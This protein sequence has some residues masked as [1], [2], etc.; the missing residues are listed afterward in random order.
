[1]VL[2]VVNA[3]AS[4]ACWCA[5]AIIAMVSFAMALLWAYKILGTVEGGDFAQEGYKT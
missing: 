2:L 4:F 1:M 3:P 5:L